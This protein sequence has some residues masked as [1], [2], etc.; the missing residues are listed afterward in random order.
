L[1]STG[2]LVLESIIETQAA[3]SVL[4]V[5][6]LRPTAQVTLEE[7]T[8]PAWVHGIKSSARGSGDAL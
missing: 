1:D 6:G 7:G 8:C 5:R 4:F 3:G 2:K